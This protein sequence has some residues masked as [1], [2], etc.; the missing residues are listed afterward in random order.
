MAKKHL[1]VLGLFSGLFI[2]TLAGCG[3]GRGTLSGKVSMEGKGPLK[4]GSV[5]VVGSDGVA[6]QGA[7]NSDGTYSVEGIAPGSVK[8]SVNSPDPALSKSHMRKKEDSA[9]KVDNAGWFPIPE[10]YGDPQKSGLTFDLK[11]GANSYNIDLK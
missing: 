3:P 1:L 4:Y 6:K 10:K 11:T 2:L 5:S 9:P 8:I 7:I